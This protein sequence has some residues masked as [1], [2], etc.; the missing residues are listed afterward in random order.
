MRPLETSLTIEYA[1]S[2]LFRLEGSESTSN[3]VGREHAF[4]FPVDGKLKVSLKQGEDQ[5]LG[6]I[7]EGELLLVPPGTA[8][9]LT[10]PDGR[11]VQWI[12]VY[13]ICRERQDSEARGDNWSPFLQRLDLMPVRIPQIRT[14]MEDFLSDPGS[15]EPG[16]YFW[17]QSHLYAMCAGWLQA[18]SK[19]KVTEPVNNLSLY[20]EYTVR[21]MIEHYNEQM[22]ME[23]LARDSGVSV[24]R[25]YRAFRQ[26]TG[27]SPHKYITKLRMGESLRMLAEQ[28]HSVTHV[29]HA[30]GY[31]DEFYFSRHFKKHMGMTPTEYAAKANIR[32]VCLVEVFDG[33]LAALGLTPVLT[34]PRGWIDQPEQALLEVSRARPDLILAAPMEQPLLDAFVAIS[35]T[36][37]VRWKGVPWKE[38]LLRFGSL[39]GLTGPAERW[40]SYYD[41]KVE[42]ARLHVRQGL[43]EEPYLIVHV[44]QGGY[45]V[46][47]LQMTKMKSL[48]YDDL[49]IVPPP[50]I[51]DLV[52]LDTHSLHE[53]AKLSCENILF[54]IDKNMADE[55]QRQLEERWRKLKRTR[56]ERRCLFVRHPFPLHYN[57]SVYDGLIDQTVRELLHA[58]RA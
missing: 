39:L 44:C 50:S 43:R 11:A 10:V 45:R 32:I 23:E 24:S 58:Q 2:E 35:R 37:V 54:L 14:W 15:H 42:N 7:L 49:G 34:L 19:P 55:E 8:Y 38:R 1:G 6:Y 40:L 22:D 46:Y 53:V 33:D 52:M 17:L 20:V 9:T 56:R 16:F 47:G 5:R 57:A 51:R 29:A 4:L 26:Y 31:S 3:T 18:A 13:F 12:A 28:G 27:L 25:F 48:F 36:E 30:A 41:Q 21:F